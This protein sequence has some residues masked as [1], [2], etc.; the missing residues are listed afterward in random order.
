LTLAEEVAGMLAKSR[1]Y[2]AS[3]DLLRQHGDFDSAVSRLYYAMFYG[4]EALLLV[5]GKSF[6]SHR[7]VVAAFGEQFIKSGIF[8]REMHLWLHRAF[9]K[10]QL[11]DYDYLTGITEAE[12]MELQEKAK[13]FLREIETF[14]GNEG[15]GFPNQ[16]T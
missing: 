9:E 16:G 6:S 5:K 12:V 13:T 2:L 15:I 3:A 7:A 10:R 11:S 8:P 14:L 4:A 1:R